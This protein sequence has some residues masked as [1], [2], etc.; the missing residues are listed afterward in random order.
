MKN[1]VFIALAVLSLTVAAIFFYNKY[2]LAP[3]IRFDSLQLTDLNGNGVKLEAFKD[4]KLFINFFA[5]WCGPCIQEMPSLEEAQLI[6]R[7]ENFQFLLISDEPISRLKNFQ[8][9]A[10]LQ[11]MILHTNKSLQEQKVASFPT[12]YVLNKKKEIVYS[13]V[14]AADWASDALIDKIKSSSQ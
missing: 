1:K 14:G 10:G 4:K 8:E 6:L 11:L 5:T 9:Q 3:E 12:S 2:R 7:K 13:K